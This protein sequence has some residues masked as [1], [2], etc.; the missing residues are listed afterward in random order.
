MS[1]PDTS[2][3]EESGAIR[4][5]GRTLRRHA[6]AYAV[7]SVVLV[8]VDFAASEG[9]WF[10]WPVLAWGCAVLLH[11]IHVKSISIDDGW[12]AD[13]ATE[14]V[15]KAYDLGHIESIR[16]RYEG[17]RSSRGGRPD[18]KDGALARPQWRRAGRRPRPR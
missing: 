18:A 2:G 9:W 17:A 16:D 14:V 4:C 13:R 8:V 15:G 6:W 12:A 1:E 3:D 11:Y 10:F 7:C 5:R